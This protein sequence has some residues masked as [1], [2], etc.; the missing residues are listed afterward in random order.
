M[1]RRPPRSTLF[2]YTTL[3]RS[4]GKALVTPFEEDDGISGPEAPRQEL[5]EGAIP[6]AEERLLLASPRRQLGQ[7][8]CALPL[9]PR[10]CLILPPVEVETGL[11]V[12]HHG[13]GEGRGGGPCLG[14]LAKAAA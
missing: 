14:D 4:V 13:G 2:P 12:K 8:P 5:A 11:G 9:D 10:V 7:A 3:F 1:I 6:G